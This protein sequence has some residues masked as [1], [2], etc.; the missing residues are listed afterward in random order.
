MTNRYTKRRYS[1]FYSNNLR[2]NF[3]HTMNRFYDLL[4][5]ETYLDKK[6]E[7]VAQ[8]LT[9]QATGGSSS[10]SFFDKIKSSLFG[11]E[12]EAFKIRFYDKDEDYNF[13]DNPLDSGISNSEKIN[14]ISLHPWAYLEDKSMGRP[15]P[16]TVVIVRLVDDV[17]I[18]EEILGRS[19]VSR[20]SRRGRDLSKYKGYRR[21]NLNSKSNGRARR[22]KGKTYDDPPYNAAG[23]LQ[24]IVDLKA[25]PSANAD[26]TGPARIK[27]TGRS[28]MPDWETL[29]ALGKTE[30]MRHIL[31]LISYIEGGYKS[32]NVCGGRLTGVRDDVVREIY[33]KSLTE[34]SIV[35]VVTVLQVKEAFDCGGKAKSH[36]GKAFAV[37]AYQIVPKTLTGLIKRVPY[38]NMYDKFDIET[39]DALG[40][41]LI[42]SKQNRHIVHYL[43]G[44][45][46]VTLTQAHMAL[47]REWAAVPLPKDN[48]R[49]G[50]T[51]VK[52]QSYHCD[53]GGNPKCTNPSAAA[54]NNV[55]QI[56]KILKETRDKIEFSIDSTIVKVKGSYK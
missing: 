41:G 32:I 20:G 51:R 55:R 19:I 44:K 2:K 15:V 22:K 30:E 49:D 9:G 31:D 42:W 21:N 28:W 47:A 48:T 5:S 16:G 26:F 3:G 46:G 4:E 34:M 38:I 37:G 52:G 39:Q 18:I 14:L 43:F 11:K 13:L 17:F 24:D 7:F 8:I 33:K 36:K 10:G 29:K 56:S 12:T 50:K 23:G 1:P 6:T 45:N 54:L 27:Q 53:V 25:G 35:Q 40:T